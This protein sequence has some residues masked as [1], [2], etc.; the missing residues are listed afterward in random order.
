[1][2]IASGPW[3]N[4]NNTPINRVGVSNVFQNSGKP[5]AANA[6]ELVSG[7]VVQDE[8]LVWNKTSWILASPPNVVLGGGT[9]QNLTDGLYATNQGTVSAGGRGANIVDL[10]TRRELATQK[11]TNESVI[12]GGASNLASGYYSVIQGGLENSATGGYSVII[13][14]AGSTA[15]GVYSSIVSSSDC[16]IGSTGL[17]AIISS[18]DTGNSDTVE[19]AGIASYGFTFSA[20]SKKH[21]VISS[22][23]GSSNITMIESALIGTDSTTHSTSMTGSAAISTKAGSLEYN[24]NTMISSDSSTCGSNKNSG[25]F[26]G[27]AVNSTATQKSLALVSGKSN[28]INAIDGGVVITGVNSTLTQTTITSYSTGAII[29]GSS[30]TVGSQYDNCIISGTSNYIDGAA[31]VIMTG[32]GNTIDNTNFASTIL[33]GA[34]CTCSSFYSTIL[35]GES[36]TIDSTK[37]MSVCLNGKSSSPIAAGEIHRSNRYGSLSANGG[38]FTMHAISVNGAKD[39]FEFDKFTGTTLDVSSLGALLFHFRGIYSSSPTT[40]FGHFNFTFVIARNSGSYQ[41]LTDDGA[42]GNTAKTF[43]D[44]N[45][46]NSPLDGSVEV[47]VTSGGVL[48]MSFLASVGVASIPCMAV[49]KY[50]SIQ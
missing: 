45:R 29:S 19:F 50:T 38:E 35:S 37:S 20:S 1:M 31:C 18:T 42:A 9:K 15:G 47:I 25:I 10:Q 46:A 5:G 33:N 11:A 24:Y 7:S 3:N 12:L 23:A 21:T 17:S 40:N 14:S 2:S 6:L 39:F 27:P 34:N 44:V 43:I 32:S 28:T 41:I 4:G 36:V 8:M 16:Q 30:H 49:I 22:K 26:V 13:G 48:T